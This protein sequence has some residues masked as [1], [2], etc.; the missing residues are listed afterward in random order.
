MAVAKVECPQCGKVLKPAKPLT[1]GKKVR[2]PNCEAVFRVPGAEAAGDEAAV[3]QDAIRKE[4]PAQAPKKAAA[5]PQPA[6]P[7]GAPKLD[8]DEEGGIY[9]FI[10]ERSEERRVG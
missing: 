7:P 6:P 8:E 1:P 9:R 4:A 5:R 3:P 2:C 10:E